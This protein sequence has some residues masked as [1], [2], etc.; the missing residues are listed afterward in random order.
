LV[1]LIL[2]HGINGVRDDPTIGLLPI[3]AA[4]ANAGYDVLLFDLRGHGQSEG[5]RSSLGWN[6]RRDLKGALDW[7][8]ARGYRRI[9]AYGFS[10]GAATALLTAAEDERI[11]AIVSDSS[12][13]E[14]PEVLAVEVP[15]RSGLP[16]FYTPGV[17]LSVRLLYGVDL[18]EIRP[19]DAMARLHDRPVLILHGAEDRGVPAAHAEALWVARYGVDGGDRRQTLRLFPGAGHVQSYR[20]DPS[21]YMTLVLRFWQ[22][23]LA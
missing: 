2:V 5:D 3:A 8:Q 19:R 13:T 22:A 16:S 20:S 17:L 18:Y 9:G 21:A 10:M 14:L 15:K 1:A 6:E 7:A 12:Y 11:A 23:A 4:L